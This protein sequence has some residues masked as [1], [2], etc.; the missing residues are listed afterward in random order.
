MFRFANPEMLYLL[1][2]LPVLVGARLM[3]AWQLR[4]R[5]AQFGTPRLVRTLVA[6]FSRLR[7]WMKFSLMLTALALLIVMA[8]RPQYGVAEVDENRVGIEVVL[9]VDVSNSMLAQDVQ[10]S[11]LERARLFASSL[12]DGLRG[13]KVALCVFAGEAWPQIPLTTDR[14][15]AKMFVNQLNTESVSL[16]GTDLSKAIFLGANM[17]SIDKNGKALIVITDGENHGEE[18]VSAAQEAAANGVNVYVLGIGSKEG[19]EIPVDAGF[20]KDKSGQIVVTRLDEQGCRRV[21]EAGGGKYLHLDQGDRAA[22]LLRN[23]LSQLRRTATHSTYTAYNEQFT[24]FAV[25]ALL[26]LLIE[27][28]MLETKNPVYRRWAARLFHRGEQ[29]DVVSENKNEEK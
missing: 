27:F 12:V 23:E 13:D 9:A 15:A 25:L 24:A 4:R 3:L 2:L 18:A 29:A 1:L 20:L 17:F 21:A 19:A 22:T 28:F 10:P 8:A 26:L 14:V 16:Q 6:G 11:R 5:L 7:P